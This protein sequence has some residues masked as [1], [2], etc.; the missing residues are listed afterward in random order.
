MRE[1]KG[2]HRG[3]RGVTEF[4]EKRRDGS[5]EKSE[6]RQEESREENPG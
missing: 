1:R 3:H 6:E 4:T 2:S 5:E